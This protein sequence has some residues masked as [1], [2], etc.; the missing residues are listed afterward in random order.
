[1]FT[2]WNAKPIS[3][4]TAPWNEIRPKKYL[5]PSIPVIPQE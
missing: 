3:L 1:M 4:G 2:P 5:S